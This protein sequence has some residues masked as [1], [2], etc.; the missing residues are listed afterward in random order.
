MKKSIN[1]RMTALLAIL[2]SAGA[3]YA[4][5]GSI[6]VPKDANAI[7]GIVNELV[8]EGFIIPIEGQLNWYQINQYRLQAALEKAEK[9]DDD[10]AR[11]IENLRTIVGSDVDINI[12][13]KFSANA[14]S[15]DFG[16][17]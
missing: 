5:D 8:Q 3:V 4:E 9:G 2:V 7:Q 13:D 14:G 12:V 15:Q 10:I 16:S 17:N 11:M 1:K 6:Q